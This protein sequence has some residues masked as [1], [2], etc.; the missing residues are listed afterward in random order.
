MLKNSNK[1]MIYSLSGLIIVSLL[2]GNG[3]F[4]FEIL[5]IL[6]FQSYLRYSSFTI[7]MKHQFQLFNNQILILI[8][9]TQICNI[10]QIQKFIFVF[11]I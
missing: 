9:S 1:Y 10:H 7:Y 2:F 6:Q 3:N 5:N 11:M 8:V 4:F